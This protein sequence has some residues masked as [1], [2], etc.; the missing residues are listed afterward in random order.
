M[1]PLKEQ[2]KDLLR[3]RLAHDLVSARQR[4]LS[5]LVSGP[6]R[7]EYTARV[8]GVQYVNDSKATFLDATLHSIAELGARVVWIAG[9]IAPAPDQS[10]FADLLRKAVCADCRWTWAA[11]TAHPRSVPRF[12][13]RVNWHEPETPCSL[14]QAAQAV[15][16]LPTMKSV[17]TPLSSRCRTCEHQGHKPQHAAQAAAASARGSFART[18]AW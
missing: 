3:S 1:D 6:H 12:S 2:R 8:K 7:M 10:H 14:A 15:R 4:T 18:L 5:D 13:W 16:P 17:A 11:Y 9:D